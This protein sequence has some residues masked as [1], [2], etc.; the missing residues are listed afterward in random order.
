MRCFVILFF[1]FKDECVRFSSSVC[2]SDCVRFFIVCVF[3]AFVRPDLRFGYFGDGFG[4]VHK[5]LF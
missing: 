3:N 1:L 4:V 2:F 5:V